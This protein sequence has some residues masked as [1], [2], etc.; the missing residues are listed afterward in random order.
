MDKPPCLIIVRDCRICHIRNKKQIGRGKKK[1]EE[2]RVAWKFLE[3]LHICA[4][5]TRLPAEEANAEEGGR[6]ESRR[7]RNHSNQDHRNSRQDS[8]ANFGEQ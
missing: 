8:R 6:N 1:E 5:N 4:T 7:K 3:I 2:E